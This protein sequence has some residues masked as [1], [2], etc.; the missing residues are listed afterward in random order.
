MLG[1]LIATADRNSVTTLPG[2]SADS[3][4]SID[5]IGNGLIVL[6]V[7]LGLVLITGYLLRKFR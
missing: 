3:F 5:N 2:G 7:V 1:I 4:F 6:G